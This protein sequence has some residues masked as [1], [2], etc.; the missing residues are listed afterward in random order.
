M[1]HRIVHEYG[2]VEFDVGRQT[3]TEDIP[4]VCALL[5]KTL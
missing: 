2:D 5:E 3:V 4:T 1:T